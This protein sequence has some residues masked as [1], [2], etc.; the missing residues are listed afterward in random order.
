MPEKLFVPVEA[1]SSPLES[2]D[3]PLNHIVGIS[4]P[5]EVY[6]TEP[7][8]FGLYR[9]YSRKPRRELANDTIANS[10]C[11][12]PSISLQAVD[13]FDAFRNPSRGFGHAALAAVTNTAQK[14]FAPFANSSIFRA[15]HW[16]YT[17]S[18]IKSAAE[19]DRLINDV[20]LAE[21][22]DA[23]HFDNG[24]STAREEHRLDEYRD[25]SAGLFDG[26][27]RRTSS[28]KLRIPKEK[29]KHDSEEAT[30]EIVVEDIHHRSLVEV[31]RSAYED[32]SV[33]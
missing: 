6:Q 14:W 31:I 5:S 21:D 2:K 24:F 30:P 19:L 3:T 1:P 4:H 18:N 22:F 12:A 7:N 9:Q 11:D 17:G 16:L 33:S 10:L 25:N 26:N 23:N 32:P 8:D 28:V 13:A 29:E 20:I 15:M 27:I